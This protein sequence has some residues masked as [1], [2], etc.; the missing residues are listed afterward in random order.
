MPVV[1]SVLVGG[2]V[3]VDADGN[4]ARIAFRSLEGKL[5]AAVTVLRV[6]WS[7]MQPIFV[8]RTIFFQDYSLGL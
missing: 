6:E 7:H 2:G 5:R 8:G 3:S 4:A 1:L